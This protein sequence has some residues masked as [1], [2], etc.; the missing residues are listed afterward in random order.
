M[1][2]AL[3]N[4]AIGQL[5]G[6]LTPETLLTRR[7]RRRARSKK[8]TRNVQTQPRSIDFGRWQISTAPSSLFT[9]DTKTKSTPLLGMAFCAI[10]GNL[11]AS[12]R[13]EKTARGVL[14]SKRSANVAQ[15]RPCTYQ[16]GN[17]RAAFGRIS[18]DAKSVL[19]RSSARTNM[20]SPTTADTSSAKCPE[21]G[22]RGYLVL[23]GYGGCRT[24][25]ALRVAYIER[26][27]PAQ[28][29]VEH[30]KENL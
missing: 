2:L 4:S 14:R 9:N 17:L 5:P 28:R 7:L 3:S 20:H 8:A 21:C 30:N 26:C 1:N 27:F 24:C 29:A 11:A 23:P 6:C 22:T 13:N 10:S 19:R 25:L 12:G 16:R 18:V 15:N